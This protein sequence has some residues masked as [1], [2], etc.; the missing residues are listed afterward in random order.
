M[1]RLPL[2]LKHEIQREDAKAIVDGV[3]TTTKT[4]GL[5]GEFAPQTFLLLWQFINYTKHFNA[6]TRTYGYGYMMDA[7]ADMKKRK[8]LSDNGSVVDFW[9]SK[10]DAFL[11]LQAKQATVLPL[12][13]VLG[14]LYQ[15]GV[16]ALATTI[17]TALTNVFAGLDLHR[18][19]R[20]KEVRTDGYDVELYWTM[21]KLD[22]GFAASVVPLI[23]QTMRSQ[24]VEKAGLMS[25]VTG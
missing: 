21:D 22:A 14:C 17:T 23:L 2:E 11:A 9:P 6:V 25:D 8:E 24:G 20:I 15:G 10:A 13:T 4:I 5:L 1:G 19:Y 12:I 18:G 7:T 16:G 3:Y